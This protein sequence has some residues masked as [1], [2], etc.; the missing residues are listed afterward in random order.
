VTTFLDFLGM[1]SYLQIIHFSAL[2]P[3]VQKILSIKVSI[4]FIPQQSCSCYSKGIACKKMQ[5]A[6]KIK[7]LF[8]FP[9]DFKRKCFIGTFW[10]M[11]ALCALDETVVPNICRHKPTTCVQKIR[12]RYLKQKLTATRTRTRDHDIRREL[13]C[14]KTHTIICII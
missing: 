3:T 11:C 1:T 4:F 14:P 7:D 5:F 13:F 6:N 10:P 9:N 8:S 12:R 2:E